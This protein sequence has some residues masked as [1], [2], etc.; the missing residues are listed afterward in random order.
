MG[1]L[2]WCDTD[3]HAARA[4]N[5]GEGR[6]AAVAAAYGAWESQESL[7]AVVSSDAVEDFNLSPSRYVAVDGQAETMPLEDAVVLLAEA[8]E[9]R[10]VADRELQSVLARL[11]LSSWRAAGHDS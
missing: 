11:G 6:I 3:H 5:V 10:E 7:S 8:E 4:A 9:E 2:A 1:A